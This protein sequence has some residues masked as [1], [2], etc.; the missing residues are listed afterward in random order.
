[1]RLPTSEGGTGGIAF[2]FN[3]GKDKFPEGFSIRGRSE[4]LLP[5]IFGWQVFAGAADFKCK[6][7]LWAKT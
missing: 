6:S 3:L 5:E 4:E 1:M 2:I 7:S